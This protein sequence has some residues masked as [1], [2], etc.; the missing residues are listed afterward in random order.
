MFFFLFAIKA[1]SYST[2]LNKNPYSLTFLT[3]GH[4]NYIAINLTQSEKNQKYI[5]QQQSCKECL[6]IGISGCPAK[7]PQLIT[8]ILVSSVFSCQAE[9]SLCQV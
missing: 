7:T 1:Y 9:S 8:L 5:E 3:G 4:V 2:I 6:N